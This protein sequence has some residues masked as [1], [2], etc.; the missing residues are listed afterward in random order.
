MKYHQEIIY[1]RQHS[2]HQVNLHPMRTQLWHQYI[3]V[4]HFWCPLFWDAILFC[5]AVS[6][7]W[8]YYRWALT[9]F[10]ELEIALDKKRG[11]V[12]PNPV[13][14]STLTKSP[15]PDELSSKYQSFSSQFLQNYTGYKG[16][17]FI[18]TAGDTHMRSSINFVVE[19]SILEIFNDR[20]VYYEGNKYR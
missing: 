9:F 8:L 6:E 18:C 16:W 1:L 20:R 13:V 11:Q 15:L 14:E 2:C 12:Q 3:L 17:R 10:N 5:T 19:E 7:I 4:N